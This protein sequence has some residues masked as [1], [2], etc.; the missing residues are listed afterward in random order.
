MMKTTINDPRI[1]ACD[2]VWELEMSIRAIQEH[3][4]D[5][6]EALEKS[7]GILWFDTDSKEVNAA[8]SAQDAAA[9]GQHADRVRFPLAFTIRPELVKEVETFFAGQKRGDKE[10]SK[11]QS[12]FEMP[13]DD[14]LKMMGQVP[15][16]KASG[17]PA[18]ER[19]PQGFTEAPSR[20]LGPDK[21]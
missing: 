16:Y 4:D 3:E 17:K 14:F 12:M 8:A 11:A 2:D 10:T 1:V 7:L 19:Q 18:Q 6:F 5:R 15:T 13:K 9:A 20:S 21:K